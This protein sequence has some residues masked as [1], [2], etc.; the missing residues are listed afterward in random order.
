MRAQNLLLSTAL[1]NAKE[2]VEQYAKML[3]E[4]EAKETILQ[5]L[6][7]TQCSNIEMLQR[8]LDE[9]NKTLKTMSD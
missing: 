3:G 2:K 6:V 7:A 5:S 4:K 9:K 8:N 1:D